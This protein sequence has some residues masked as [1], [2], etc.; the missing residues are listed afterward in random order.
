MKR[1]RVPLLYGPDAMTARHIA[2]PADTALT[3]WQEVDAR[4]EASEAWWSSR[5]GPQPEMS[6]DDLRLID[7]REPVRRLVS[8]CDADYLTDVE[9]QE[10]RSLAAAR[11]WAALSPDELDALALREGFD[12]RQLGW[13]LERLASENARLGDE[14]GSPRVTRTTTRGHRV[15][16]S[17]SP[18]QCSWRSRRGNLGATEHRTRTPERRSTSKRARSRRS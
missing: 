14:D 3:R 7:A 5:I 13:A 15:R 17:L 10:L 8:A 12:R 2:A 6:A 18:S 1:L 4:L 16:P 9:V 11:Q